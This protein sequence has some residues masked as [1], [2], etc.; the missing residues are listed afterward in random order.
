MAIA[1]QYSEK[2]IILVIGEVRKNRIMS[3]TFELTGKAAELAK[4][5]NGE[6]FTLLFYDRLEESCQLLFN[7]GSDKILLIENEKLAFFNQE[8]ATNIG[9]EIIRNYQPE[10]VLAGATTSGRTFLPAIAAILHTGLTADCTGLDIDP[11]SGLLL[12][13]RPA[14]GGNVMATIKTP[15]FRPQMATVR[16]KTFPK[17]EPR[18]QEGEI[19]RPEIPDKC[20]NSRVIP[21]AFEKI[22]EDYVNIQD[23]DVIL[24][25]GKGLKKP[26]NFA[27]LEELASLLGGGVGATRP[28]VEAKW[29]AYPHQVGLSGK[30]VSPKFYLAAGVSGAVQHLAGMQTSECI[31]AVNK[32]PEA[33]IFQVADIGLCGDLFEI[34]PQLIAAIKSEKAGA[35]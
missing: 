24:T 12:Q 25:G 22:S 18:F 7:Y 9:V 28:T 35:L 23:L 2:P 33:G 31:V 1:K 27:L 10:I 34:L 8:I 5:R 29:I 17:P 14:I 21:L 26:E 32:D 11:E 20:F 30:V 3:V 6:V 13:T 16:P 15:S 4:K 19:I